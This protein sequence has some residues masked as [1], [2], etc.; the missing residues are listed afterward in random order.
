MNEKYIDNI[1]KWENEKNIIISASK[2]KD[3]NFNKFYNCVIKSTIQDVKKCKN[4]TKNKDLHKII[5][6]IGLDND[7]LENFKEFVELLKFFHEKSGIYSTK[8]MDMVLEINSDNVADVIRYAK[9]LAFEFGNIPSSKF[10]KFYDYVLKVYENKDK[11]NWYVELYGLKLFIAY[12]IGK[13]TGKD[14]KEALRKFSKIFEKLIDKIDGN[15]EKFTNFKKFFEA[16]VAYH[17][18]YND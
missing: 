4:T 17:R 16:V 2:I 14:K 7:K 10:R 8:W 3:D 11:N 9:I 15:E 6:K 5:D 12:N 18:A 13:E 1:L